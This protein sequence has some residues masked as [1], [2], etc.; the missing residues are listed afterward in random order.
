MGLTKFMPKENKMNGD[1]SCG[2][3]VE[4]IEAKL[5]QHVRYLDMLIDELTKGKAME[6]ILK[7]WG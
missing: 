1:S 5:V 6:K 4:E 7:S 3:R 2:Y